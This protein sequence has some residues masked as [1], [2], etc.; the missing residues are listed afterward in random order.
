MNEN[1]KANDRKVI[2]NTN[3]KT[4]VHAAIWTNQSEPNA[5][6]HTRKIATPKKNFPA[7]FVDSRIFQTTKGRKQKYGS[8][9]KLI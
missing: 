6:N 5:S 1:E 9:N 8:S 3:L 4:I 2:E 7:I